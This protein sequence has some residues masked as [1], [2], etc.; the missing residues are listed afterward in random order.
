M[1]AKNVDLSLSIKDFKLKN[2]SVAAILSQDDIKYLS[3][4]GELVLLKKK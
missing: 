3:L 1:V 4:Y 2:P